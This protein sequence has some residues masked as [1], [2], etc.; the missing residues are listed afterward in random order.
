MAAAHFTT[1][2]F[3]PNMADYTLSHIFFFGGGGAGAKFVHVIAPLPILGLKFIKLF[4]AFLC[5][6]SWFSCA[7]NCG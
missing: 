6:I 5:E 7:R 4:C 1:I 3:E 2:P